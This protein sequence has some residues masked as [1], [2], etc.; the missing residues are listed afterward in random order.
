[1][2]VAATE[3]HS[4]SSPK[5]S[6]NNEDVVTVWFGWFGLVWFAESQP[7]IPE[8]KNFLTLFSQAILKGP[9]Y[10]VEGHEFRSSG[11][12]N[13]VLVPRLCE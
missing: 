7:S 8:R 10:V 4:Y 5:V 1:M 12:N 6:D 3:A 13:C 9:Y 11:R 2:V